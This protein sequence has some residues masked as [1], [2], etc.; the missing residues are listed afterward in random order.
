MTEGVEKVP[1][2]AVQETSSSKSKETKELDLDDFSN[3]NFVVNGEESAEEVEISFSALEEGNLSPEEIRDELNA[4][5]NKPIEDVT[6]EIDGKRGRI[7]LEN[8]NVSESSDTRTYYDGSFSGKFLPWPKHFTNNRP[9]IYTFLNGLTLL[10]YKGNGHLLFAIEFDGDIASELSLQ[11]SVSR[12][13]GLDGSVSGKNIY[14]NPDDGYGNNYSS[15]YSFSPVYLSYILSLIS[16]SSFTL[17]LPTNLSLI[18]SLDSSSSYN[19]ISASDLSLLQSISSS[20]NYILSS[21]GFLLSLVSISGSLSSIG[22]LS[23]QIKTKVGLSGDS[24]YNWGYS[25]NYGDDYGDKITSD[26]SLLHSVSSILSLTNLLSSDVSLFLSLSTSQSF[27]NSI[28]A[29]LIFD[30][31][32]GYYGFNYGNPKDYGAGYGEEYGT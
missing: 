2:S 17:N 27:T 30:D 13:T 10:T 31:Y 21:S 6:I 20:S 29:D 3:N 1:L 23:G 5:K 14:Y 11:S 4:L 24:Y 32:G 7:A 28:S 16:D 18:A 22:L 15:K 12:I 9:K 8:I 26:L 19:L 25:L